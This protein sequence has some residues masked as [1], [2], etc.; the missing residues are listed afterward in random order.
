MAHDTTQH[1]LRSVFS[2]MR[3]FALTR[4]WTWGA[5]VFALSLAPV[6]VNLVRSSSMSICILD[7]VLTSASQA[8]LIIYTFGATWPLIGCY[9]A[10]L[11]MAT[12]IHTLYV[13]LMKYEGSLRML[14]AMP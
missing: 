12:K 14:T 7:R 2:G 10:T 3:A 8:D 11:P 13:V 1:I 9:K 5:I 4:R 6:A